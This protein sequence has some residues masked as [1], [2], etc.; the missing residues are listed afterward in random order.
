MAQGI[1]RVDAFCT[2][3]VSTRSRLALVL[4]LSTVLHVALLSRLP[5]TP[6]PVPPTVLDVALDVE[7]TPPR[8]RPVPRMKA[9]DNVPPNA[10]ESNQPLRSLFDMIP[11]DLRTEIERERA[12]RRGAVPGSAPLPELPALGEKQRRPEGLMRSDRLASGGVRYE[13]QDRNGKT[14]VWE[15]PEPDPNDS[16][17]LNL[18]R[19]GY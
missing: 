18:C 10:R 6:I 5:R 17:A 8:R 15:C 14:T 1:G 19:T 7:R 3:I 2:Y 4:V 9:T 16:F 13:Y 11:D 12:H